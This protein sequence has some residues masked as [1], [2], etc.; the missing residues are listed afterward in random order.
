MRKSLNTLVI[1]TPVGVELS[2]V[3]INYTPSLAPVGANCI[4]RE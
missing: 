2:V 1:I 3:N 4:L